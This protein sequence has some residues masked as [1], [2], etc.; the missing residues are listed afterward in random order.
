MRLT[1][2]TLLVTLSALD[3]GAAPAED[4]AAVINGNT[5]FAINLYRRQSA[6]R[7]NVFFS[8]YSISTAIAMAHFGARGETAAEIEKTM[9]SPF[10]GTRLAEAWSAVLDDVNKGA[11]RNELLT[12]NAMWAAR[13][14]KFLDAYVSGVQREFRGKLERLDFEGDPEQSRRRINAWVSETT[15]EKIQELIAAGMIDGGTK[16]VLTNAIYMN[17]KWESPFPTARTKAKGLFHAPG[18]DI[19]TPMMN[20]S[21][22]FNFLR[23]D[24]VRV[25]EL[26]YE[27]NG[28][29]MVII[30]PDAKDGLTALE[31]ELT[32]GQIAGWEQRLSR[33]LVD[34]TLPRFSIEMKLDLGDTLAAM[35]MPQAFDP[36]RAD[37]SGMTGARDLFLSKVVHKARVDVTEEGTEAAAATAII[38]RATA[39]PGGSSPIPEQFVAD[40]PF[41]FYIR[42]TGSNSVLFV[43]RVERP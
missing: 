12:A 35:G 20:L 38:P 40:H 33:R 9:R 32:A 34:V 24:G 22:T 13:D 28:L 37:F 7:G 26:P 1:A 15:R 19:R 17:A 8:P 10:G 42:R 5:T 31:K 39:A 2:I 11:R 23:A 16:L 36:A 3:A 14:A 4:R 30:L 21:E 18:G 29:S 25:L 41:Y 43:G 27:G 6:V